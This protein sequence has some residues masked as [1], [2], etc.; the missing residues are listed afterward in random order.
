MEKIKIYENKEKVK[1]NQ[2]KMKKKIENQ[3][4]I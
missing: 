3:T 2:K 4:E 1:Q